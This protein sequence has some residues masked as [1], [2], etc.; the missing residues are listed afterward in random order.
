MEVKL[1][2][3]FGVIFQK[4]DRLPFLKEYNFKIMFQ[5]I[6]RIDLIFSIAFSHN[7]FMRKSKNRRLEVCY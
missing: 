1:A 6:K 2:H 7:V 5:L 4:N 3:F